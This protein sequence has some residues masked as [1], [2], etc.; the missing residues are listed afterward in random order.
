MQIKIGAID[1]E[2]Q[3]VRQHFDNEW[4]GQISFTDQVIRISQD[5]KDPIPTLLHEIIHGMLINMGIVDHDEKFVQQISC[6]LHQVLKDNPDLM[7]A[8]AGEISLRAQM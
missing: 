8:I 6:L 5:L 7:K 2:V 4:V 3:H 1:Y